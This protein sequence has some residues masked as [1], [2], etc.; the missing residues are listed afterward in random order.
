MTYILIIC[1]VAMLSTSSLVAYHY[2][3]RWNNVYTYIYII[4]PYVFLL[5]CCRLLNWSS[6]SSQ[7]QTSQCFLAT[8]SVKIL[9]RNS[10]GNKDRGEGLMRIRPQLSFCATRKPCGS[11]AMHAATSGEIAVAVS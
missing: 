6:I 3:C 5:Q 7:Y 2:Y 8:E 10:S 4:Y 11:S 9:L 1:F